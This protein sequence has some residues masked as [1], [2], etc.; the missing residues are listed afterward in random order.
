MQTTGLP[1]AAGDATILI[2]TPPGPDQET[3]TAAV[4]IVSGMGKAHD[5]TAITDLTH[6][7]FDMVDEHMQAL[8]RV[9]HSTVSFTGSTLPYAIQLDLT[10]DPDKDS[11][12][13]LDAEAYVA[14]PVGHIKSISWT[15]DGIN[16]RVILM[17][18][19]EIDIT[20]FKDFKIYL[21]GI[22]GWSIVDTTPLD[23]VGNVQAFDI[24]GAVVDEVIA[25]IH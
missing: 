11:G 6:I 13:A 19:R 10:H 1:M 7:P 21:A 17:P 25:S 14:N 5:F 18:N 20:D 9:N 2:Q 24:N 15:D 3:F 4:N 23:P 12:G 22:S 8:E 16:T